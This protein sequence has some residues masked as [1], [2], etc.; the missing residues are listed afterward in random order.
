MERILDPVELMELRIERLEDRYVDEYTCMEC[1]KK[2]DYTLICLSLL[3]D[4][5]AVCAE[6][7]RM[8]DY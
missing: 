6:Y 2:V 3:G 7:A 1:G 4:G 8:E 5:P